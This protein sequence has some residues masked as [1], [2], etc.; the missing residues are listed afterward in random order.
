MPEI[1]WWRIL[2]R[3]PGGEPYPSLANAVRVLINDPSLGPEH[4]WYDLSLNRIFIARGHAPRE[5]TDLDDIK[6]AVYLQSP[7][8]SIHRMSVGTA[9][10]A[11]RY[12][13]RTREKRSLLRTP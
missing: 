7:P 13:A 4:L 8:F 10:K 1:D 5:W 9:R 2:D 12:I 6:L 3:R 11:A